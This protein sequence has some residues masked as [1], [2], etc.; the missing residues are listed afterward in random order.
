MYCSW[1]DFD[2]TRL[3]YLRVFFYLFFFGGWGWYFFFLKVIVIFLWFLNGILSRLRGWTV[4]GKEVVRFGLLSFV[5]AESEVFLKTQLMSFRI[6]SSILSSS[7]K[8]KHLK[9]KLLHF[10]AFVR[11]CVKQAR[12]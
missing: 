10:L 1:L 3:A 5:S 8:M 6:I 11:L 4:T 9:V 12:M 7:R 2:L